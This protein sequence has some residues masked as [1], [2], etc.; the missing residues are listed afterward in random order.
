MTQLMGPKIIFTDGET[1]A[2]HISIDDGPEFVI[3][4][5]G[6]DQAYLKYRIIGTRANHILIEVLD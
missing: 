5:V 6:S 1:E 2:A 3:H 4:V